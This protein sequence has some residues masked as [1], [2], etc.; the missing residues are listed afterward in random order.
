MKEKE[1]M[2]I[3]DPDRL[4]RFGSNKR[5]WQGIPSIERTRGGRLFAAWYSGGIAEQPGNYCVLVK[6]DDNG[7]S[8]S[9]P[10]ACAYKSEMYRCYDQCLWLDPLGRLWF[11]WGVSP[12]HAVYGVICRNPDED[13]LEWS[14]EFLIGHDVMLN[15]PTVLSTGEWLFPIAV[16]E[17]GVFMVTQSKSNGNGPYV[18]RSADN[19]RT[20][21]RLGCPHVV[22]RSFDE[23]MVVE[24]SDDSLM[25]FTRT[26]YGISRS[27]SYD[28]GIT[29][30]D[31][32][33]SQIGGPNSRFFIG[34]LSSG[35]LLLVNH[36][37]FTGR[38]NLTALLSEDDG[39][40]WPYQL[41]LDE[42]KDVSYPDVA[43]GENGCLYIVYDHERG[44][45]YDG[46]KT[47]ERTRQDSREILMARI[48]EEDI[49][50]GD[51]VSPGSR[52]QMCIN[53]LGDY[54]GDAQL[55]YDAKPH[56][57]NEELKE[58]LLEYDDMDEMLDMLFKLCA[59]SCEQMCRMDMKA[60]DTC[61]EQLKSELMDREK[62]FD[63]IIHIIDDAKQ[64]KPLR[65]E[66]II[67]NSIHYI[68]THFT[69]NLTVEE[70]SQKIGISKYYL[71]HMFKERVG[72]SI[73]EYRDVRRLNMAK[74]LLC[75]TSD[76]ITDVAQKCGFDD[77]NYFTRRF[78]RS[79]GI[80]PTKFRDY[81]RNASEE[82]GNAISSS[83][84]LS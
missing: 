74:M 52:L 19:G 22:A 3:T 39:K 11:S 41:L 49:L 24:M 61:I 57:S 48:T 69:E 75:T 36:Y 7:E 47:F 58:L 25:M 16:W 45:A 51:L 56:Y 30:T 18:Y 67:E 23:H 81:H 76:S 38:N 31:A 2:L 79:I 12:E 66:P 70:L 62:V 84:T 15:K 8:F 29:W 20:F 13:E 83:K 73:L 55:L 5:I 35:R 53:R 42:R 10:I 46:R 44:A 27:C 26:A 68:G 59:K 9:E 78:K 71:C 54:N 60:L 77:F 50:H 6:S 82:F 34:R 37:R 72:I 32:E 21:Q 17:K 63:H 65:D 40:T 4:K 28:G 14:D 64:Q 33:D 80:T 1:S 43:V